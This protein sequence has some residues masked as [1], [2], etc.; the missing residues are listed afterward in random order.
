MKNILSILFIYFPVSAQPLQFELQPA[1]FPV[2]IGAWQMFQPW[3]GGM[4][5]TTPTF[6]DIDNDNDIDLFL[7]LRTGYIGYFRNIG[8]MNEAKFQY[9]TFCYDSISNYVGSWGR[10]SINFVD[11]DLDG[12]L[13]AFAG[14]TYILLFYNNGTVNQPNFSGIPDT[15]FDINM[16]RLYASDIVVADIDCD[17]DYDI[18]GGTNLSGTIYF[19]ENIGDS[20][21][22]EYELVSQNWQNIQVTGAK[23]DP[24]TADLDADGDLDLLVGTGQGKI[25]YYRN[26]GTPQIPQ[27]VY[28]TDNFCGIDVGEDASPELADI[29][30]DGDL[31]LFVGRDPTGA[32]AT[33][34]QGDVYFYEN[35][36][37]PQQYNYQFVTTNYLTFDNGKYSEPC[38]VDIDADGDLDL[39]S[40]RAN[41]LL[42]YRN[43]GSIDNPSF[44]YETSDFDS[45][46]LVDITP[47]FCD[48]DND[49]D[50]DLFAGTSAIPG[51]PG[52]S[53]YI[54][55]G[56]PEEPDYVLFSDNIVP[57]VFTTNSVIIVPG[58][59]DIDADGDYDLFVSD[60]MGRFFFWD[61]TGTPERFNFQY[62]TNN[63]QN[64]PDDY[65]PH[66]YF[67][68]Y[69]IEHDGDL[70]LFY[71]GFLPTDECVIFFYRNIGTPQNANMILESNNLF[72][73]LPIYS[74]A[75]FVTDI[76]NDGDGDLFVGD[77]YGGIRFF[78]NLEFN[79]V[80]HQSSSQPYS[81][82]LE[83]C[84]PN[85]FNPIT[86]ISFTLNKAL[87]VRLSVYNQ[88][89]QQ[90]SIIID[91]KVVPGN[92]QYI[93]DAGKF[94]SG[95]YLI[96][97][98][99]PEQKQTQK[100]ILLK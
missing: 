56:T 95:V 15:L 61:N 54:N 20:T 57:G 43:Q 72:P 16:N 17:G 45:F 84:Y 94:S 79:S 27:M 28:V 93:W 62:I 8:L 68:F 64:I 6:C 42:F 78:R 11:I 38:L 23:S 76:D 40:R 36:G 31:D 92:Y 2:S 67:S 39:F 99:S 9:I 34:T 98:E 90:V 66:R 59:A 7:G 22:Y 26:D 41:G 75:P 63:W 96:S 5:E 89:G 4:D 100:I 55:Q 86:T 19:Y 87:P 48:I 32:T 71:Y 24:C 83:P 58:V 12:D 65:E 35:I 80:S 44:V 53:L 74:P 88:L 97:L 91:N 21:H 70:D 49:G 30:G 46:N 37:T 60:D 29:D 3:A 13:D 77:T 51:P 82:S 73:D 81:F 1:A 50:L 47:C 10:S 33:V 14:G 85:P 52:L 69:D 18:L 25:Y